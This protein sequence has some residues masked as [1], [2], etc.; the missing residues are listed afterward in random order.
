M[1]ID[2]ETI[3]GIV[4][5]AAAHCSQRIY[6]SS[7]ML[8]DCYLNGGWPCLEHAGVAIYQA[9]DQLKMDLHNAKTIAP[10]ISSASYVSHNC[11]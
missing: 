2:P 10:T 8:I 9:F 6:Y 11:T 5:D 1:K 3:P 7:A 4:N